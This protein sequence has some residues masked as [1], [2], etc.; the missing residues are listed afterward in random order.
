MLEIIPEL[1][2]VLSQDSGF[3]EKLANE[4]FYES[5]NIN[6]KFLGSY[7]Q[8]SYDHSFINAF[9]ETILRKIPEYKIVPFVKLK[10]MPAFT[11]Q[12]R[13]EQKL[14]MQRQKV[15]SMLCEGYADYD[16]RSRRCFDGKYSSTEIDALIIH[17]DNSCLVEYE[18]SKSGI[19][20]NIM[21]LYRLG[22]LVDRP[23]ESL[24]VTRVTTNRSEGSTT[25]ENF[26]KH[27]YNIMPIL[28]KLL[29]DWG[30]LELVNISGSGRRRTLHWTLKRSAE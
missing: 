29:V 25:F 24:L 7:G 22:L 28:D 6:N 13:P 18:N 10:S 4:W 1:K 21:K 16:C 3:L 14:S 15:R 27:I 2:S 30:I 12:E 5:P 9:S 26:N 23:F 19:C 20:E 11:P 8:K 17:N